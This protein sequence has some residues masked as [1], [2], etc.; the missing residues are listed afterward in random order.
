MI[1]SAHKFITYTFIISSCTYQT[2]IDWRNA[3]FATIEDLSRI[4]CP[5][6]GYIGVE[7]FSRVTGYLQ[8]LSSSNPAK[9]QEFLDRDRYK[10]CEIE[11]TRISDLI[12]K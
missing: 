7:V 9:K 4:P 6:C 2:G 5:K 11:S 12:N 3:R 8:A 1:L 10:L